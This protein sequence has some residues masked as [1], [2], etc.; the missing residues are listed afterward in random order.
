MLCWECHSVSTRQL[1]LF[2]TN[3]LMAMHASMIMALQLTVFLSLLSFVFG[4][5]QN[6][7]PLPPV[8]RLALNDHPLWPNLNQNFSWEDPA[9][10]QRLWNGI[11]ASRSKLSQGKELQKSL[12]KRDPTYPPLIALP[13]CIQCKVDERPVPDGSVT[14]ADFTAAKLLTKTLPLATLG[15]CVFYTQRPQG[16]DPRSLSVPMKTTLICTSLLYRSIWVS[17]SIARSFCSRLYQC[18]KRSQNSLIV[19]VG[20]VAR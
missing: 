15:T 13:A 1:S 6:S 17:L 2:L 12:R 18:H 9:L 14:L 5:V 10:R 4:K 11:T 16:M 8:P 20:S 3:F 19:H 7:A